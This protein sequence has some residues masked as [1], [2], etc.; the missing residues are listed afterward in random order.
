MGGHRIL[1]G[2]ASRQGERSAPAS[3]LPSYHT[4]P[5]RQ[6]PPALVA[7]GLPGQMCWWGREVGVACPWGH[8]IPPL[9]FLGKEK[10]SW[11]NKSRIPASP[12]EAPSQARMSP[13]PLTLPA[14][15]C[16]GQRC[17]PL[18]PRDPIWDTSSTGTYRLRKAGVA[19]DSMSPVSVWAD[20]D[21]PTSQ[22]P[23][24][25]RPRRSS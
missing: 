21:H 22:P 20:C 7:A 24:E 4:E 5:W 8:E 17:C 23:R 13:P 9:S 3:S 6:G 1:P 2:V 10:F 16:R 14:C 19:G 18:T 11:K 12:S 15:G 25:G